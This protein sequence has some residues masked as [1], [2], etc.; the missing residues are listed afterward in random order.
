MATKRRQ[1]RHFGSTGGRFQ[2]RI[3]GCEDGIVDGGPAL[4]QLVDNMGSDTTG[5]EVVRNL[6]STAGLAQDFLRSEAEERTEK[7]EMLNSQ[8]CP[9]AQDVADDPMAEAEHAFGF[10]LGDSGAGEALLQNLDDGGFESAVAN[11][12]GVPLLVIF[13]L[14]LTAGRTGGGGVEAGARPGVGRAA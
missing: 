4:E 14:A 12:Q 6:E 7:L 3:D 11:V 13:R 2:L 5:K 8:S 9:A 1:W 10:A